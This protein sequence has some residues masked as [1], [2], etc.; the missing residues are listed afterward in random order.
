MISRI[1][2][3]IKKQIFLYKLKDGKYFNKYEKRKILK[4]ID[5]SKKELIETNI[6]LLC[7]GTCILL[8]KNCYVKFG[9][10]EGL[11]VYSKITNI[12]HNPKYYKSKGLPVKREIAYW[13]DRS[14]IESRLMALEILREAIIND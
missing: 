2:N 3:Y 5:L 7:K 9:Y 12:Y 13:W 1:I 10:W 8:D 11:K 14:D 4:V 6:P